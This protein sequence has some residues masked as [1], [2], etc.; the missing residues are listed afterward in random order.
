MSTATFVK[1]KFHKRPLS[2][3]Y[4]SCLH[5]G[6]S[7]VITATRKLHGFRLPVQYCQDHAE[8]RGAV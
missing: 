3:K 1:V 7:A 8:L 4:S 6:R 2:K 5:C